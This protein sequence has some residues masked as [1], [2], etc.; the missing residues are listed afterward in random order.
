V[1]ECRRAGLNITLVFQEYIWDI[2]NAADVHIHRLCTTGVEAWL[3]DVPS[4]E[5]HLSDYGSWNAKIPGAAAEAMKGNDVVADA[6]HLLERVNFYLSGGQPTATQL[7]A[8][9]QYIERWL[10]RVDGQRCCEHAYILS[11]L[12]RDRKNIKPFPVNELSWRMKVNFSLNRLLRR[13]PGAQM[14]FWQSGKSSRVDFI[15]QVDKSFS[16]QDAQLWTQRAREALKGQVEGYQRRKDR[17][18]TQP[19]A[20]R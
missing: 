19:E 7:A 5:L 9:K 10:Y 8:R 6:E 2:L 1:A 14:R 12:I 3:L 13:P 11:E 15:G 16:P 18:D 4:L 17:A 20:A